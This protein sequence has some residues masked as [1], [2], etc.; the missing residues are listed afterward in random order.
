MRE[1]KFRAWSTRLKKHPDFDEYI[2][3]AREEKRIDRQKG[4][5]KQFEDETGNKAYLGEENYMDYNVHVSPKG[6]VMFLE[7]GW[8]YTG[9]E[10]DAVLM[11]Y[12]GLKDKNGVEIYEGDIVDITYTQLGRN[13][14][15]G[16]VEKDEGFYRGIVHFFPSKGWGL[17]N[18]EKH[19]VHEECPKKRSA[20]GHIVQY[21]SILRGNIYANPDLLTTT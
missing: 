4:T 3:K 17:K 11:Q 12:T 2:T 5:V 13:D 14:E 1:I 15:Y 8:D 20:L 19:S 7:G 18:V 9:D 16:Y 21:K 10:D 6:K